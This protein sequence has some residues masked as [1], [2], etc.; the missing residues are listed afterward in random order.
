MVIVMSLF[1]KLK[2]CTMLDL[3]VT[4]ASNLPASWPTHMPFMSK[5]WNYYTELNEVQ[6]YVPS[7]NPYQTRF[8]MIDEH[9]GTHFDAPPHF[10]PPL[11]SGLP[12]SSELG[13]QTGDKVSLR[14]L[15]GEAIVIDV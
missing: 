3:S 11:D 4:V 8:W 2:T 10:I 15:N 9:C 1:S 5:I 12:W 14:D 13:G 6:G 7:E